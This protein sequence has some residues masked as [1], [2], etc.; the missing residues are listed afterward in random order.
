M[1]YGTASLVVYL[2]TPEDRQTATPQAILTDG[3]EWDMVH[4]LGVGVEDIT[5]TCMLL[6]LPCSQRWSYDATGSY[7]RLGKADYALDDPTKWYA[8]QPGF[9]GNTYLMS[10]GTVDLGNVYTTQRLQRNR[11][12]YLN[13]RASGWG[14]SDVGTA[15]ECGWVAPG[16]DLSLRFMTS[17]DV[18][19]WDGTALIANGQINLP[20]P[21]PKTKGGG[22]AKRG[23]AGHN[24][25]NLFTGVCLIPM[26]HRE[27]LVLSTSGGGGFNA[28]VQ[29]IA[30][31]AIDP[32]ITAEGPF[33][34]RVPTGQA[35][36]QLAPLRYATAGTAYSAPHA[37][38]SSVPDPGSVTLYYGT[39]GYGTANIAGTV[40]DM[41]GSAL[42]TAQI[43]RIRVVMNG[44]GLSSPWVYGAAVA[45]PGSVTPGWAG[46]RD[47]SDY[48]IQD[49]RLTIDVPD[50]ATDCRLTF[51]L[52]TPN[53]LDAGDVIYHARTI[54]NRSV[55]VT[56]G[57]V[58]T[59]TA[60]VFRGRTEPPEIADAAT[61]DAGYLTMQ[62]RDEWVLFENSR[63]SDPIPLNGMEV[64]TAVRWFCNHAGVPDSRLDIGTCD[65]HIERVGAESKGEWS[66]IPEVGDTCAQWIER[67][68][69]DYAANWFMGWCPGTAGPVF[70]FKSMEQMGTAPAGTVF[71][72]VAA[73]GGTIGQVMQAYSDRVLP[74]EAN[75]I[76]VIGADPRTQLPIVAHYADVA[77]Q[78]PALEGTARPDNWLGEPRQYSWVNPAITGTAT[79]MWC[80]GM[81]RDRLPVVRRAAEITCPM[82]FNA[83]GLPVWRGDVLEVRRPQGTASYRV[84]A[85]AIESECEA[86]TAFPAWGYKG[87][88]RPT[89]YTLEQLR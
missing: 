50:S 49:Q 27:L 88:W 36:V 17:G 74:I 23:G 39:A 48:V 4:S 55:Q 87:V 28:V 41:Y 56:C 57:T 21:Y 37:L 58:P 62:A 60:V 7:A 29:R 34:W 24:K 83:Q 15:L 44:D 18:E 86:G 11:G 59:G 75:D 20:E 13:F 31:D 8:V 42:G 12:V 33:W 61:E 32:T 71:A 30:P 82:Q 81:L 19:V 51:A 2:D 10:K 38:R 6:P 25:V 77:S 47:M 26:R 76:W 5:Q 45:W 54:Q 68:H 89:R 66:V 64:G 67:M 65:F 14:G 79:A 80:V 70:R 72:S 40:T 73:A 53:D 43:A 78:D 9:A 52:A 46:N 85:M 69:D 1:A 63:I 35:Q 84:T 16:A 22:G 3:R